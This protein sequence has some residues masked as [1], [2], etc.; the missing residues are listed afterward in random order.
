MG[1]EG[2]G[3]LCVCVGG[4]GVGTFIVI[5]LRRGG[6]AEINNLRSRQSYIFLG[7]WRVRIQFS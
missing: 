3:T 6:G 1:R 7:I 5:Y 2:A 4:G